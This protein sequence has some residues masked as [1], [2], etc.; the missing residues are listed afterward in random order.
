VGIKDIAKRLTASVEDLDRARLQ[1]RYEGLGLT[2]IGESPLR[3]PV[4]VGGEITA[5][6]VVPRAGSPSLEITISD[7]SGRVVAV[8]TGRRRIN[9]I[10]P[11]RGVLFEGVT[12]KERGRLLMLNPAYTL[13]PHSS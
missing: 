11:S 2:K 6:Q 1:T 3:E 4:R 13:L 10:E 9:G 5:M 8:F 7:G 12:R